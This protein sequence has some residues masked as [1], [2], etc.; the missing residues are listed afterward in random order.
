M[1]NSSGRGREQA[2]RAR[3]ERLVD[4]VVDLGEVGRP[5]RHAQAELGQAVGERRV[6]AVEWMR[7]LGAFGLQP[8][9]DAVA[10]RELAQQREIGVA[11]RLEV[12]EDERGDAVA[13]RE[14]DLGQAVARRHRRNER[15]QRQDQVADIARQDVA[16]RDLG[17][18]ARL[19]LVEA[20]QH[21]ALLD[22]VAHRQARPLPV[23][24]VRAA[25]RPEHALG[26]HLA[27]VPERVLEG[28]LLGRDLRGDVEVL[29]LA[30]AADAEVRAARH[31]ALRALTAQ[32]DERRLLPVV[33]APLDCD[34][35]F[36]AR[37]RV[38]DEHDLAFAVVGNALRLEIERLDPQPFVGARHAAI[39][40]AA[41]RC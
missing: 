30:A 37:Q 11:E 12:A 2:Q 1:T 4:L 41:S 17:D 35:H 22:D 26:P 8:P 29:H 20:D 9:F 40:R 23:V 19:A 28:A 25:H 31:D 13:G 39:I 18:E 38:L 32:L 5:E 3:H 34:P 7:G 10:A 24:P 21:R 16:A 15:A 27:E 14:L 36:L 6:H 33:L